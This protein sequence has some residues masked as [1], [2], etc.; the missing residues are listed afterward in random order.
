MFDDIIKNINNSIS[1]LQTGMCLPKSPRNIISLFAALANSVS[2][3]ELFANFQKLSLSMWS[4]F[5]SLQNVFY[6]RLAVIMWIARNLKK[7]WDIWAK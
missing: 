7:K 2:I 6:C 4:L 5:E 1:S 3:A